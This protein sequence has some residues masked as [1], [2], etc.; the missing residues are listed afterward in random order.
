MELNNVYINI[1]ANSGSEK[2]WNPHHT[3]KKTTA[4]SGKLI[5]AVYVSYGYVYIFVQVNEIG[6]STI[7]RQYNS[8]TVHFGYSTIRLQYNSTTVQFG[9]STIRLQYNSATVQFDYSTIRLQYNSATVQ[10]GYSTIRLQY[11]SATIQFGYSTIPYLVCWPVGVGACSSCHDQ[12]FVSK[13]LDYNGD[14][15]DV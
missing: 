3:K 7:R 1:G 2:L 13:T 10:F 9:Y 6:Y 8:A 4:T 11:N 12:K 14:R 15:I 5:K